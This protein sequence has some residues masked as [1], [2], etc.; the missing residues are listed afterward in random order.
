MNGVQN[1]GKAKNNLERAVHPEIW[2]KN[3]P[4]SLKEGRNLLIPGSQLG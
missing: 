3:A 1:L 2:L 4:N